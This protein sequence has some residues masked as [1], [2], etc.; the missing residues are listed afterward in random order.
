MKLNFALLIITILVFAVSGVNAKSINT[1]QYVPADP[2]GFSVVTA[3]DDLPLL[4]YLAA[5]FGVSLIVEHEPLEA[6][7]LAM[8]I[9]ANGSVRMI[10][11]ASSGNTNASVLQEP[12]FLLIANT[13]DAD[14]IA[15]GF[16]YAITSADLPYQ[17]TFD[18]SQ[19]VDTGDFRGSAADVISRPGGHDGFWRFTPDVSGTYVFS[20]FATKGDSAPIP[21]HDFE[22]GFGSIG[23]WSGDCG[24]LTEVGVTNSITG[25]S[26]LPVS[27]E[28]GVT[29][30]VVWEDFFIGS[31]EN[32]V[33]LSIEF[34]GEPVGNTLNDAISLVEEI[35]NFEVI[36]DTIANQDLVESSCVEPPVV[37][38]GHGSGITGITGS[39]IWYRLPSVEVDNQYTINILPAS[40]DAPLVDSAL[41]L[42]AYNFTT[43]QVAEMDC[44]N[45]IN[46]DERLSSITFTAEP[47]LIYYV[48]VETV[49]GFDQPAFGQFVLQG[50]GQTSS[51]ENWR[52]Y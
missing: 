17:E 33:R 38:E 11:G 49:T 51:V 32:S 31:T 1:Y 23:V 28:A 9:N 46:A 18:T 3:T 26:I 13:C 39:E 36:G 5:N 19:A 4:D 22:R 41:V 24:S 20:N 25:D 6:G 15:K 42:H 35:W 30:V 14:E 16:P 29:Y 43:H 34:F 44:S 37:G 47:N 12:A 40:E 8:I 27:L 48:M 2:A 7:I 52:H 10:H 21:D 45:D 50:L